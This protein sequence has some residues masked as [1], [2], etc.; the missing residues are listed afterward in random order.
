MSSLLVPSV[1]LHRNPQLKPG[2][3]ALVVFLMERDYS[4]IIRWAI[5]D[6][7]AIHGTLAGSLIDPED[8]AD[9][10]AV[11]VDNL[12]EL[13]ITSEA[14]DRDTAITL[15]IELLQAGRHPY[16]IGDPD[17]GPDAPDANPHLRFP[18]AR[19][20]AERLGLPPIAGGAP[21]A[22]VLDGDRRDFEAWLGQIDR[23]LPPRDD[24]HSPD[25]LAR[26]NLALYGRSEPHHA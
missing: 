15:D 18:G 16:P 7:V 25:A 5:Y 8:E 24:R 4:S 11:F 20:V 1:P 23:D 3:D 6:H 10:E 19:T 12:P 22:E 13:D 26:I 2:L 14:W 9:A 21:E 17:D